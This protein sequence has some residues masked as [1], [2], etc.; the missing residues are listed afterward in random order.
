MLIAEVSHVMCLVSAGCGNTTTS[1][2]LLEV[3]SSLKKI[4]D[5]VESLSSGKE[6]PIHSGRL[7]LRNVREFSPVKSNENI[8]RLLFISRCETFMR[9]Y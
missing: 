8:H 7:S 2:F 6:T 9:S 4:P 5:C 1:V 3:M